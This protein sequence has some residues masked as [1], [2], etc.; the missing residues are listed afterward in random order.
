MHPADLQAAVTNARDFEAA[1]LEA[2]HAQ[3]VNLVMNGSSELDSKLKQFSDSINQKLKKYLADN[4]AI[5]QPSQQCNNLGI[6]NRSENQSHSS[7]SANQPWQ[8]E[9]CICHYCGKQGHLRI[10][11]LNS[12]ISIK[13]RNILTKLHTYDTATNLSAANLSANSTH[14]LLSAAP[15]HLSA[16]ALGNLLAVTNSNTTAELTLK[17]NS[18]AK[19][20][21]AKLEIIDGS[22]STNP[23]FY[24]TIIK[25]STMEFRYQFHPKSEFPTLFKSLG[26]SRRLLTS[27]ILLATITNDKT[28]AAIF[29]FELEKTTMIPLFSRATLEEKLITAMYTNVKVNG[30]FI[31]LILNSG[32]AGSIITKQL[33]DQL[34]NGIITPINVLVMETTQYQALFKEEERKPTWK[35]YQVSWADEDHNE[36]LPILSWD[37]NGKGKQKEELTWK[38]DNLTWTDNDENKPTPNW[39]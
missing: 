10:D 36:L 13:Y 19:I 6:T 23:Q 20:N 14:H 1:E 3:A 4:H 39:E 29:F 16:I 25:F 18:K 22:P 21:T 17:Q 8:Q 34:V 32:S 24:S 35:A 11:F 33:M 27:N 12:E 30:H 28:L 9:T 7:S 31:K 5:Y 37:N 26:Y 38:T 2:N 15:T